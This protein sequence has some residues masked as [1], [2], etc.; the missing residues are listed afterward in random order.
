MSKTSEKSIKF[1]DKRVA[2]SDFYKED[3]KLFKI[4]DID[5]NKISISKKVLWI[6]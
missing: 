2:K 5:V 4:D 1:G 6:K 3:T